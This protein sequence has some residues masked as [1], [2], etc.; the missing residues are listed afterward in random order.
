MTSEYTKTTYI[1][2]NRSPVIVEDT[3]NAKD[4]MICDPKYCPLFF[5]EC[6]GE[7]FSILL[8]ELDASLSS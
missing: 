1:N 5:P 3:R 4:S 7:A 2:R 8:A 6:A